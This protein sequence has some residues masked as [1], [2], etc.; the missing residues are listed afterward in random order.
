MPEPVYPPLEM[1]PTVERRKV[2]IWS[3]GVA[4]DGDVYRPR[5]VAPDAELPAVV[6]CHGWG[7]SKLTGERYAALFADAGMITLTFT[8]A[9]WFG[10]GARVH[11]I[12]HR[13]NATHWVRPRPRSGSS[14]TK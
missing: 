8:Q 9:T 3:N 6:L 4:L 5:Q 7:G 14:E 12:G 10:S 2:T 13:R 1:P 11:L